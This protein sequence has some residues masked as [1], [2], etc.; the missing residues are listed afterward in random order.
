MRS[1]L[2]YY[3][4]AVS[5]IGLVVAFGSGLVMVA[6]PDSGAFTTALLGEAILFVSGLGYK[7]ADRAA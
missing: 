6:A 5:L 4:G 2:K 1:F 3:F 7:L